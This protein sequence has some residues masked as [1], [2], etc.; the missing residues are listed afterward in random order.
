MKQILGK[1]LSWE[2]CPSW[3][4]AALKTGVLWSMKHK[5]K[6]PSEARLEGCCHTT[7]SPTCPAAGVSRQCGV[8]AETLRDRDD[9]SVPIWGCPGDFCFGRNPLLQ[10][11]RVVV[12]SRLKLIMKGLMYC[13]QYFTE[14][15]NIYCV[16]V[17]V[18]V[19][20]TVCLLNEFLQSANYW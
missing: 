4:S 15:W 2:A 10:T 6:H 9:L 18:L 7:L 13:K 8:T 1:T 16:P 19:L 12:V 14:W 11:A 17:H 20:C 5:L 3:P